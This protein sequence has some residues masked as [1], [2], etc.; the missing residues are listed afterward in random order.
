MHRYKLKVTHY[1]S[2]RF[3]PCEVCEKNAS[4]VYHQMARELFSDDEGQFWGVI[5]GLF[6]HERCL[7]NAR[8]EPYQLCDKLDNMVGQV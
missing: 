7:I 2:E 5:S 6:G 4:E 3:G 8:H 1:S